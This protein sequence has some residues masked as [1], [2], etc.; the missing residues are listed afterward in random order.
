MYSEYSTKYNILEVV[1]LRPSVEQTR[2]N[3][4]TLFIQYNRGAVKCLGGVNFNFCIETSD[5]ACMYDSNKYVSCLCLDYKRKKRENKRE[6][7]GVNGAETNTITPVTTLCF[8]YPVNYT[9]D[10]T[11]NSQATYSLCTTVFDKKPFFPPCCRGLRDFLA[12]SV[13]FVLPSSSN[14]YVLKT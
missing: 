11:D 12:L 7:E 10:R 3:N 6:R 14:E 4:R 5:S 8:G 2:L 13:R 9:Y 1:D